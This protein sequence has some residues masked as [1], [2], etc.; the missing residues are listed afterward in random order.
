MNRLLKHLPEIVIMSAVFMWLV[1]FGSFDPT[2]IGFYLSVFL[3]I[4]ISV[5]TRL[6]LD[7]FRAK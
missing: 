7:R 4:F 1:P 3:A 5:V 2:Q 6:L